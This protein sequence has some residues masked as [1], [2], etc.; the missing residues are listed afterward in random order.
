MNGDKFI[1]SK[2]EFFNHQNIN[3]DGDNFFMQNES[4]SFNKITKPEPT[5][6]INDY[7]SNILQE[8]AYK[9][10]NDDVFKLEYKIAKIENE[11]SEINNQIKMAE[12]IHDYFESEQ[13]TTRKTKLERELALLTDLYNEA[14]LS[15]KISG[16]LTSKIKYKFS[17][18]GEKIERF[19]LFLLSKLPRK[20]SSIIEIRHSLAILENINKNVDELMKSRYP[21]GEAAEKYNQLSKYIAKANSIQS[22]IYGFMK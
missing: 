1:S 21:Y 15:A 19:G 5:R 7:D 4:V 3:E 22:E 9:D 11:I 17:G 6:H 14:S 13:L 12:E 20:L 8:D 10:V 18:A 16:G 2:K